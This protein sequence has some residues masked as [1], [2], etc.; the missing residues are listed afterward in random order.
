M[1]KTGT[2]VVAIFTTWLKT[3]DASSEEALPRI[4]A[5]TDERER[6]AHCRRCCADHPV[7]AVRRLS[8]H[9]TS[10]GVVTYF[11]CPSGHADFFTT[12]QGGSHV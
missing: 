8:T 7:S 9:R 10:A 3:P 5:L 12:T 4:D 1:A 11:R 2:G 6:S